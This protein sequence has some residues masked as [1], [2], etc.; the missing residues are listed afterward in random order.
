MVL[1]CKMETETLKTERSGQMMIRREGKKSC[2]D[3][4][5]SSSETAWPAERI[6][7]HG[8]SNGVWAVYRMD[9]RGGQRAVRV[10]YGRTGS[11][12]FIDMRTNLQGVFCVVL[13]CGRGD[14]R[15][16]EAQ[17]IC[18]WLFM[19]GW[20]KRTGWKTP[21]GVVMLTQMRTMPRHWLVEWWKVRRFKVSGDSN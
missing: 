8:N 17:K 21:T 15:M 3:Q 5:D 9:G 12:W 7:H 10:V 1:N 11:W 13:G 14:G 4:T 2:C 6:R 20:T 18:R 19:Y 16:E